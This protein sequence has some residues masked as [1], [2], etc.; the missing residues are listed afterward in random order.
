MAAASFQRFGSPSSRHLVLMAGCRSDGPV[1]G[2]VAVQ[3]TELD[4]GELAV[5]ADI[6]GFPG[7]EQGV[8]DRCSSAIFEANQGSRE[9]LG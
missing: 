2:A 4:G 3:V 8:D 6:R 7:L 9:V 5:D 1:L